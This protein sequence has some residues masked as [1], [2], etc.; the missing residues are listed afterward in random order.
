VQKLTALDAAAP[1]LFGGRLDLSGDTLVV[2][3]RGE[4]ERGALAGAAYIFTRTGP[5]AWTQQ[6]KVIAAD[7]IAGDE[8]GSGVSVSGDS[9]IIGSRFAD[10]PTTQNVGCA[11]VFVRSGTAWSQQVRIDSPDAITG[12]GFG[13][14]VVIEGDTAVIGA[15]DLDDP[16]VGLNLGAAYLY[17]RTGAIWSL[18]TRIVNPTPAPGDFFGN[19]FAINGLDVVVGARG[20]AASGSVTGAAY[21]Y[22]ATCGPVCGSA[23]FDCDGDLGTD[24]DIE[25]FFACLGGNCP[26]PPCTSTADFNGDGDIGTDADIEAFFRVLAGGAC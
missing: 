17:R 5:T 3:A 14:T 4:G 2:G 16:I 19:S 23:D 10:T 12:A 9:A 15:F 24:A 21:I 7:T 25:A 6:A 20:D 11:Y 18:L 26:P 1:A 22:R 8:L 13:S